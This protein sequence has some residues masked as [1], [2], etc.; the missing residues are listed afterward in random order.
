MNS[1]WYYC[2]WH[3]RLVSLVSKKVAKSPGIDALLIITCWL[4]RLCHVMLRAWWWS[5][6]KNS[7]EEFP[8]ARA[9]ASFPRRVFGLVWHWTLHW[10]VWRVLGVRIPWWGPPLPLTLCLPAI[11]WQK[12]LVLSTRVESTITANGI[13][14]LLKS[15]QGRSRA[16]AWTLDLCARSVEFQLI[17]QVAHSCL[18]RVSFLKNVLQLHQRKPWSIWVVHLIHHLT[19]HVRLSSGTL[20]QVLVF[21]SCQTKSLC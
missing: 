16:R 14:A 2:C 12:I 6:S 5:C 19:L 8:N 9:F 18:Q 21:F 17:F 13:V 7:P 20:S 15:K 4:S 11:R 10:S 1:H 3:I